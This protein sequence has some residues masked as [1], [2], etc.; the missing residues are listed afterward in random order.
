MHKGKKIIKKITT[1]FKHKKKNIKP[2]TK[3]TKKNGVTTKVKV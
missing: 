1:T 3:V 2:T